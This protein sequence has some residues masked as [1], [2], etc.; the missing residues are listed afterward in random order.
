M[1]IVMGPSGNVLMMFQASNRVRPC[2]AVP[3]KCKI[4]SPGW[5]VSLCSEAAPERRRKKM[6]GHK[7]GRGTRRVTSYPQSLGRQDSSGGN[8]VPIPWGPGS[9][10]RMRHLIK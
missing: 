3:A 10:S 4:S 9:G 2:M 1:T 6:M 5:I 7:G 8:R